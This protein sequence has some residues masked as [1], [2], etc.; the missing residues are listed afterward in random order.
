MPSE[1]IRITRASLSDEVSRSL[2]H[3]LNTELLGIYPEPGATHFALQPEEV[4]APRGVF[5][6]V[7]RDDQPVGCGA[8]RLIDPQTGELKRMYMAPTV[9]GKGLGRQLIQAL[10]TEARALGARR[11]I[12]ET[13][14][15]QLAAIALYKRSGFKPIPLYGEYRLSPE[16]SLCLGKDL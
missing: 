7:Y 15:R 16:T 14:A 4:A 9:R 12:L 1:L 2:I 11:L 5:L 8:M 6:V 13:G 10:E 3:A